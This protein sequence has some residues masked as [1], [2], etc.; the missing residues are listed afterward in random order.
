MRDACAAL[1]PDPYGL[2]GAAADLNRVAEALE[3]EDI[4]LVASRLVRSLTLRAGERL[5]LEAP[6]THD[7]VAALI[8]DLEKAVAALGSTAPQP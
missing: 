8:S 4:A 6:A 7:T 1:P 5:D 3:L 2:K